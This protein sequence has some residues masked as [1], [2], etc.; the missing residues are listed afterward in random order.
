M[1]NKISYTIKLSLFISLI[2][3]VLLCAAS[4]FGTNDTAEHLYEKE[5]LLARIEECG[6]F[7][8]SYV[9]SYFEEW[10]FPEFS[11]S[12]L[13][14]VE[15]AFKK[16]YVETLPPASELALK[17]KDCFFEYFFDEIDL[18]DK[19]KMTLALIDCFIYSVGDDYAIYRTPEEY[20][21]YNEDMSG[22]IIGIG[23]QVLFDRLE[24]TC[25]IESV[26]FGSGAEAA[27]ILPGDYIIAVDD[28]PVSELGYEKTI[29]AVRG[30]EGTRVKITVKR[31]DKE[32]SFDV[33]RSLVVARSVTYS[34]NEEK[35]GYIKI[36]SFK[37]N[38]FEQFKEAID[39]FEEAGCVGVIYDLQNNPGGYLSAVVDMLSY[40]APKGTQLVSFSND[41]ASPIKADHPH[42]F[43]I[44]T[45]V[46][47]NRY[48]AS[49]G[50]LFTAAI[51]DFGKDGMLEVTIVGETSYGKGI[52]Q[53]TFSFSDGSTITMT[54]AYYNP[55]SG[56]NYH[57]I[58]ITPDVPSEDMA[59]VLYD[60]YEEISKLI[61]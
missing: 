39:S 27:G 22:E 55:P 61:K 20:D 11:A 52:M 8:A 3:C 24:N 7:S 43:L 58:G 33:T 38:T 60:A 32:L 59:G 12:R 47:C 18:R 16:Q 17:M 36:T 54:V 42:T 34:I 10:Y 56:V 21:N 50:E 40:I 4:C 45:V 19:E 46:I 6:G 49:A 5:A 31:E 1:K 25:L 15:N 53:N 23:V 13:Y 2:L 30:E 35:I 14:S 28:M 29:S 57:K 44:P 51:R 37:D 9:H 26:N 41:Y 48:T